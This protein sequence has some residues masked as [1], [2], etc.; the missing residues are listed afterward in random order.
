MFYSI[1]ED[2][3]VLLIR[4]CLLAVIALKRF[5]KPNDAKTLCST[6]LKVQDALGMLF[7]AS[8][9]IFIFQLKFSSFSGYVNSN[10]CLRV[11]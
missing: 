2:I 8:M 10:S 3:R 4:D 5:G 7:S 11:D 6:F 1:R 9:S